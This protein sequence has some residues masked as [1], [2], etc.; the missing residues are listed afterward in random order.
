MIDTPTLQRLI[1]S[2]LEELE[3][4]RLQQVAEFAALRKQ[5]SIRVGGAALLLFMGALVIMN[6]NRGDGILGAGAAFISLGLFIV[7]LAVYHSKTKAPKQV[8][9]DRIKEEVYKTAIAHW[10]P[11]MIYQH[12]EKIQEETYKAADLFGRYDIYKGDDYF[13]GTL[14]NGLSLAFSE[15]EVKAEDRNSHNSNSISTVFKGLFFVLQLP[16][17]I[18][19]TV[20]ILPDVAE[21]SMGKLGVYFQKKLGQLGHKNSHLVYFEEYPAFEK[22]FVVYGEEEAFTRQFM[23]PALVDTLS[24]LGEETKE[25]ALSV[26]GKQL[27]M[28]VGTKEAFLKVA[29]DKPLTSTAFVNALVVDLNYSL[30]LVNYLTKLTESMRLVDS[31]GGRAETPSVPPKK[32][33]EP[34]KSNLNYKKPSAKDN[35]FLL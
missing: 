19:A 31:S 15:L 30:Q 4:A 10:Y 5:Y 2:N 28:A 22:E 17:A 8:L 18:P 29:I 21:R 12:Q 11:E 24:Q 32:E 9:K 6:I 3:R 33:K 20:K 16:E 34:V 14:P 35:P 7:A 26:S 27:Y 1:Q 25:L 13:E 23:T